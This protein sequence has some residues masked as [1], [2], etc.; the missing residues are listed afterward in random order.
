MF[1]QIF[2]KS[3]TLAVCLLCLCMFSVV[4]RAQSTTQGAIAGTVVDTTGALVP[5]AA[6]VLHNDG[7]SAEFNLVADASG[8]FKAP[9]LPPGV[10][11]VTISAPGFGTY[12]AKTVPV[13]VGSLTELRPELKAGSTQE[14]VEVT[15]VA[16]VL[17]FESPE[18]SST[19][20]TQEIV[21]LPLNGG[22][23]S[24]LALLTPGAAS[25]SNGFGLISFRGISPILNNVEIDGADNNQAFFSEERGRTRAGYSTSQ[26]AIAEFQVNTGVYSA[27]YGRSAGG[28]LN[29]VTKSGSNQLH[30][31]AYFYDRDNN[32]GALNPFTTITRVVVPSGGGTPT[33]PNSPYGPKDWRK[34]WGFGAGGKLIENKLFWF[35]AY[36]QFKRN[37]PGLAKPSS[38]SAFFNQWA[39]LTLP[40]GATCTTTS[41]TKSG[42]TTVNSKFS[43]T[44]SPGDTDACALAWRVY[45]GNY[46]TAAAHYNQLLFGKAVSSAT[47]LSG[48][49][50]LDDLGPTPRTGDEVLNTPKLDWQVSPTQ[51]VSALFHR[52]R[53][54]SPGGVQTQTSNNYAIDTFG[55]DFVKLDY[56]LVKLDSMFSTSLS[57]ELRV[58]YGRELDWEGQQPYSDFTKSYLMNSS[59]VPVQLGIYGG[60][61]NNGFTAGSP[62]YSFRTAYPEE[63][64]TQVGD[65]AIWTHNGQTIKFGLDILRNTDTINNLYESNGVYTYNYFSDFFADMLKPSGSCDS[66]EAETGISTNGV[67]Y[68]CYYGFTQGF[69]TPKFS[70]TTVDY[71]FFV[72]DDWKL[73]PR[74][75][76]NLGLR[77]D[78]E[79]V[80]APFQSLIASSL[81]N[82]AINGSG[83]YPNSAAQISNQPVDNNNFGP[84][85]GLSWDPLGRGKTVIHTGY[86]LYYGRIV[87]GVVLNA[88]EAAGSPKGQYTIPSVYGQVASGT[89]PVFPNIIGTGKFPTPS[90]DFFA[91]NFQNPQVNEFDLS[92]QQQLPK[93]TFLSVSYMGAMG[94]EL[95]NFLNINLNPATTYQTTLTVIE[96][97]KNP[98]T[99]CG[100]IACGT[101][102]T[103]TVYSKNYVNSNYGYVTEIRSNV[104][105]SYN[106]MIAEIQN[107]SS[108]YA[109]FDANYTWSHALDFN[110][111]QST[112][113]S[114][115]NW[116]D[117]LG[118]SRAN[119]GNSNFNVPNRFVAWAML[120]YPGNS[121]SWMRY[122]S[123]GWHLNPVLQW[124]NGLPYSAGVSGTQPGSG[125]LKAAGSG[126]NGSGSSGYLL[127]LGRN[128]FKYPNTTVLD[129]RL[130]KDLKINER[131]NIELLGELF[132][133]LN[134]QNVTGVSATAYSINAT[135]TSTTPANTLVYQ[136]AQGAGVNASGFGTVNNADSNFVYSQRQVQL[137]IKLDF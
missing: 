106:G 115:N 25:D 126:M 127:Q 42:T 19:L 123:D 47:G 61:S 100:P 49:G 75:T 7:T 119:Y 104:N 98:G 36:D 21:S 110:Q 67:S 14:S 91:K 108:K 6:V 107:R 56:G 5:G 116:Y 134:H 95:P 15:G 43:G 35:Y 40:S 62:Y 12:S 70:L 128:T 18:V 132:N 130:Q 16:P 65:T 129:C 137:G 68:P 114:T 133:V 82:V 118:N 102:V 69:G 51:H 27:E 97:P 33:F 76:L 38:P 37:F 122:F 88:Y 84:H 58:Q 59:G 9:L 63:K 60:S 72:Q 96:N 30:G 53:W 4:S 57:N 26:I 86:G 101:A 24:N 93:Q 81:L 2:R 32:W 48:P 39:D 29:A 3:F 117:P 78:N 41:T 111:N 10:Y 73:T 23:W 89:V 31:Q 22:R 50:L 92:V 135:A 1:V 54:D 112:S 125:S 83:P 79:Q 136:P 77:Y 120:Q 90:L 71:G 105:S 11:T 13:T 87:N 28:V 80:P 99:G 8:Y 131:Y 20:T 44:G 85:A 55:T 17:H 109:Q 52:L 74:L 103:S 64:K 94:R 45:G 113:P 124:Q 34:R 66:G 46:A 121:N